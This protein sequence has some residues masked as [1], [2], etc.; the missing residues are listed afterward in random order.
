[1]SI[2]I[3]I[4]SLVAVVSILA[5]LI[6]KIN[7]SQGRGGKISN[8]QRGQYERSVTDVV[9]EVFDEDFR[10]DLK[11]R[12]RLHFETVLNDNAMFLK[13]DLDLTTSQI[14]EYLKEQINKSL[15][16]EFKTYRETIEY[17]KTQAV[18][19]IKKTQVVLEDQRKA[20]SDEITK[21]FASEKKVLLDNFQDNMAEIINNYLLKAVGGHI[22]LNDQ[23]A[24][25]ISD[26]EAN[27][28]EISEDI[29]EG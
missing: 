27:K 10:Q 18:D 1:M 2:I 15:N 20:L 26:L 5:G 6:Y 11:N 14:H 3:I 22:N 7:F 23:L 17:A 13:Q 28:K 19:S 9:N 16:E 25:V 21:Q 24:A 8:K 4:V 12:G 29:N